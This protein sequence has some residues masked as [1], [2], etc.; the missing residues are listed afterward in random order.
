MQ[1]HYELTIVAVAD[2]DQVSSLPTGVERCVVVTWQRAVFQ[3]ISEM[4]IS[5]YWKWST[6][7]AATANLGIA[8]ATN[9]VEITHHSPWIYLVCHSQCR[10]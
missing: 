6:R 3:V 10:R 5:S 8:F 7:A 1:E 2:D 4:C 9:F